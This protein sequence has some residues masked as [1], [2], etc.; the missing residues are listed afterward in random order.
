MQWMI[1][2]S[3][4]PPLDDPRVVIAGFDPAIHGTVQHATAGMMS[5]LHVSMDVRVKPAYDAQ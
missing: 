5:P 2:W 3:G 1:P 4:S